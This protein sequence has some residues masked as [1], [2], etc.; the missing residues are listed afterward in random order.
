MTENPCIGPPLPRDFYLQETLTVARGLL[1]CVLVHCADDGLLAGR[2]SETE[3][4]RYDDPASH[5][6]R[7]RTRRNA[8]L[9]GPPGHAYIYFTYGMHYCLNAVTESEGVGAGVLIRA[10]EP[11]IGMERMALRRG[12]TEQSVSGGDDRARQ[13]RYARALTAG[14]GRLCSAFGLD[15]RLDGVDL[16]T[17]EVL[18]I[19]EPIPNRKARTSEARNIETPEVVASPR[20]GISRGIDLLWRFTLRDD[21]YVSR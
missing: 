19:A 16:T 18:W 8:T 21:P 14:P 9:F 5:A 1:G 10:L 13:V 12:L 20:I 3:A 7:G 4:Y 11:L 15:R 6:Y 2:I 17:G